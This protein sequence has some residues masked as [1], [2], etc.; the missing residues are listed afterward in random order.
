[1][2][3]QYSSICDLTELQV[4]QA[5][6]Q[7]MIYPD[8]LVGFTYESLEPILG[9]L[10]LWFRLN[11]YSSPTDFWQHV[12][13]ETGPDRHVKYV[14]DSN[15]MSK[16]VARAESAARARGHQKAKT[17]EELARQINVREIFVSSCRREPYADL[18]EE[19]GQHSQAYN[20]ETYN[21]LMISSLI[22]LHDQS[23][24]K[25]NNTM[26]D[27]IEPGRMYTSTYPRVN[28]LQLNGVMKMNLSADYYHGLVKGAFLCR[29][30]LILGPDI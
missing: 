18:E 28:H 22:A 4:Y 9:L 5:T 10:Y 20:V 23:N 19:A 24:R 2:D 17:K 15:L 25:I 8:P 6:N 21:N 29:N 7:Q 11:R 14:A 16:L 3:A 12:M 27:V 1:M 30:S 26:T 13:R